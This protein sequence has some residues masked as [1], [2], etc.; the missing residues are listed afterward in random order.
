MVAGVRIV[1]G[2]ETAPVAQ[3]PV[4]LGEIKAVRVRLSFRPQ[5]IRLRHN[6][7]RLM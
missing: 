4:R 7:L 5:T 2:I 6:L 3:S 1:I